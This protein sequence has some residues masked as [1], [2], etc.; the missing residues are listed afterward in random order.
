MTQEQFHRSISA[1]LENATEEAAAK[2]L[3]KLENVR[4]EV[5]SSAVNVHFS[6]EPAKLEEGDWLG[7][8]WNFL[9]NQSGKVELKCIPDYE[10]NW[11]QMGKCRAI[12]GIIINFN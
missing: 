11:E 1:Q 7:Q 2:V 12:A 5:L 8:N 4:D 10:Q 6:G 9:V 3:K